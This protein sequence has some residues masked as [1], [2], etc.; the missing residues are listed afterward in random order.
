MS[1][2][3]PNKHYWSFQSSLR[4]TTLKNVVLSL[5]LKLIV[6]FNAGAGKFG[7]AYAQVSDLDLIFEM[8]R[9]SLMTE[10]QLH[11]CLLVVSKSSGDCL[12]LIVE[13]ILFRRTE[14]CSGKSQEETTKGSDS[15]GLNLAT[16]PLA[17][18]ILSL[19]LT[20]YQFVFNV[21]FAATSTKLARPSL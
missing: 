3:T 13:C 4:I 2:I 14:W 5:L 21:F 8:M 20:T 11:F 15:T 6:R 12:F 1:I 16:H 19:L 17:R 18:L 9:N 7:A 10:I